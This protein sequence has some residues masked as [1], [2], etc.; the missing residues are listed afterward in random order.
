MKT[1][2]GF[3]KNLQCRGYQ[4]E[5]GKTYECSGDI[6]VCKN[7]FHAISEDAAPLSVFYFYPP[8]DEKCNLQRYCEVEADG[9]VKRDG[10]KIS[11]SKLT[12]GV[13]V[14]IL[15]L[16]KAHVEWVKD[17]TKDNEKSGDGAQIGSSGN[18]AVICCAGHGS[19]VR[20]KAG[21]W[22]TLAEWFRDDDKWKPKCVK[23]EYV[24]GER[25]KADTWYILKD[26]EFVEVEEG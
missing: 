6:E 17:K 1:I 9:T 12:V 11:C 14:G 4:Y 20:A 22:I 26:G 3:D 21:S 13:E 25:I 8:V 18:G 2:K 7:G 23:T 5:V 24:D 19:K 16:V 15:G 10:D